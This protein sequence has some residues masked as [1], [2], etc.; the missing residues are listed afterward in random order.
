MT[1][2]EMIDGILR[3]AMPKYGMDWRLDDSGQELTFVLHH[4]R[5]RA[6]CP[7]QSPIH[8][9]PAYWLMIEALQKKD[10]ARYRWGRAG[11]AI[12]RFWDTPAGL[13]CA[14][15]IV[16]TFIEVGDLLPLH[17]CKKCGRES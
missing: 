6:F 13:L 16:A 10:Q 1:S 5:I 8:S 15:S 4:E 9:S 12:Q 11:E 17:K 7:L 2:E 3:V 14:D